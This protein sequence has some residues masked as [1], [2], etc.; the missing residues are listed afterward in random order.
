MEVERGTK[1]KKITQN[2]NILSNYTQGEEKTER[3]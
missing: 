1:T 2:D 3:N